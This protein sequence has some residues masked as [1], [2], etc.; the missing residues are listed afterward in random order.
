MS[1]ELEPLYSLEVASELIPVSMNSLQVYLHRHAGDFPPRYHAENGKRVLFKSE[2]IRIREAFLRYHRV[3]A[4]QSLEVNKD[5]VR[6]TN[7]RSSKR[8]EI[9]SYKF[10]AE[11]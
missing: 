4:E 5:Y 9:P 8:W 6:K 1:D 7:R 2:C 11:A 10:L 3:R